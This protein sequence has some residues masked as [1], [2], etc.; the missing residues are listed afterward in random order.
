MTPMGP[1]GVK[2]QRLIS[3]AHYAQFRGKELSSTNDTNFHELVFRRKDSRP[4]A[5][6]T[7]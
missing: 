7:D 4:F 6:F 1:D 2:K 5:K 3:Y